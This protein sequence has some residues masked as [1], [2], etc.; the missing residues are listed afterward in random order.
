MPRLRVAVL[1]HWFVTRG[2]GERV[3]ECIAALLPTADIFALMQAPE[4]IPSSLLGRTIQSSFLQKLPWA[5]HLH[6]ELMPLYPEAARSI[7]LTGYDLVVSS[8]S[9]PIKAA[10]VPPGTPH[11]CYCHSPMRYLYDGFESY[12][13]SMTRVKGLLFA[14]LA[15]RVRRADLQAA[16]AVTA[17]IANS[18]Y[19]QIRIQNTYSRASRVIYP[20]IDVQRA[21][22]NPPGPHYLA[23]GRLVPYKQTVL[24]IQACKSLGR[25]LRIVGTGPEEMHLRQI[26]GPE[27]TFLGSLP[28]EALWD[29]YSRCRALL[30]AADE[31]FGMVPLEAQSCGRPVIAFGAGGSLETV[32]GDESD[33][34]RTG[35]F[36]AE[37]TVES[38]VEAM[39]RFEQQEA[40]FQPAAAQAHAAQFAVPVFLENMREAILEMMPGAAD[41]LAD[42]DQALKTVL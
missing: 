30:F 23:A 38:L 29:E 16:Q 18:H 8:D 42:V 15:P 3:A 24:L 21:R 10:N 22:L 32:R 40:S 25:Q 9:G 27:T 36:F 2:G 20:P 12:K 33:P 28:Q 7:D 35:L 39:L 34:Q 6:R 26:A 19:V 13:A 5:A 11:L 17:F 41:A 4:G 14:G 31:D 1:H 37:Q